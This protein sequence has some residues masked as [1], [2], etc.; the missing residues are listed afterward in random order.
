MDTLDRDRISSP[1]TWYQDGDEERLE[2]I[3]AHRVTRSAGPTQPA[4]ARE[5]Q[6]GSPPPSGP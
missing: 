2:E 3:E 5:P 6:A 1:W 4:A